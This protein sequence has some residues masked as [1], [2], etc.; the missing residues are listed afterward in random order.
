MGLRG[1]YD[2]IAESWSELKTEPL[3]FVTEFLE[4]KSGSLL[5]SGCGAGR[6]STFASEVGFEVTGFDFSERMI[7]LAREKDPASKCLVAD[8]RCLPFKSELFDYSLSVAVLHHLRPPDVLLSLRELCRVTN[9]ESLVSVWNH[10]SMRGEQMIKWGGEQRY[11]YLY[12]E[13]EFESLVHQVFSKVSR[14]SDE[15]NYV[16]IVE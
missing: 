5:V 1:V 12:D 15:L 7:E 16:Y 10:P 13:V 4:G 8:A 11:Y 3:P 14:V 2:S 9:G 6:H